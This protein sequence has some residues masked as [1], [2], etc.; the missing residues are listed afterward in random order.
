MTRKDRAYAWL[1]RQVDRFRSNDTLVRNIN[2][3]FVDVDNH[4]D[5][6]E[7]SPALNSVPGVR[8]RYIRNANRISEMQTRLRKR[9]DKKGKISFHHPESVLGMK[10]YEESTKGF[11]SRVNRLNKKREKESKRDFA[12]NYKE[13]NKRVFKDQD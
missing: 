5:I 9:F 3:R 7:N 6:N 11:D 10:K 13:M 8:S 4:L 12:R 2:H 1:D